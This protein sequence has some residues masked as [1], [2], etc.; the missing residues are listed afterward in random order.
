MGIHY[1]PEHAVIEAHASVEEA[2]G[3]SQW[4]REAPGRGVDLAAC[5]HLHAAVLQVL[6]AQRPRILA[7]APNPWL[8]RATAF[9][10]A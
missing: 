5:A 3:L 9:P 7:E 1:H 2:E 4:L 6:M 8:R 10:T